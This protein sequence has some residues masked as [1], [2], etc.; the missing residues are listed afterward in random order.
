MILLIHTGKLKSLEDVFQTFP[1]IFFH[2]QRQIRGMFTQIQSLNFEPHEVYVRVNH[3]EPGTGKTVGAIVNG[4]YLI[5]NNFLSICG[6]L[7]KKAK[8]EKG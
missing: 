6:N 1:V 8:T 7:E 5:I 2:N 3:G 4:F